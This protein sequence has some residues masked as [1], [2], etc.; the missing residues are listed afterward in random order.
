MLYT[1]GV[2]KVFVFIFFSYFLFFFLT[3]P[4]QTPDESGHYETVYWVSRGIYPV[5]YQ[6]FAKNPHSYGTDIAQLIPLGIGH[7]MNIPNFSLIQKN[8]LQQTSQ[9]NPKQTKQFIPESPEAYNPPL[10]YIFG[11]FFLKAAEL[12]HASL[13]SQFYFVRL[14]STCF[15]FGTIFFAYKVLQILFKKPAAVKGLLLFFALNPL[16]IK[17]GIGINPDIGV[18]FFTTFF[19]FLFMRFTQQKKLFS[20]RSV[21][22]LA[23][24]TSTATLTKISGIF[25]VPA[26]LT[27]FFVYKKNIQNWLGS[28]ALFSLI[29]ALPQIPWLLLNLTRYHK[30]VVQEIALGPA[31]SHL[32]TSIPVGLISGLFEFRHTFMHYAGFLGWNDVYPYPFVFTTY[33]L[34]FVVLLFLGIYAVWKNKDTNQKILLFAVGFLFLF[35]YGLS[36]ERKLFYPV[37]DIQGRY[38]LPIFFPMCILLG[39]G[40]AARLK[41]KIE[42]IAP[43]LSYFALFYYYFILVFVLLPRYYV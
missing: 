15:Y 19:L 20:Y 29:F 12:L 30:V 35:F 39:I 7:P 3:P 5:V 28:S 36:V 42:T 31:S 40:L 43:W 16:L 34:L 1:D 18:T 33:A 17:S 32:V 4:V 21:L 37:W 23:L 9:Y 38:V 10:Y 11:A 24:V 13:F 22:F 8:I 41:K 27:A 6:N 2:K 25:L 14:A 26:T